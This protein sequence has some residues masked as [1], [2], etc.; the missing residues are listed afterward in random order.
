VVGVRVFGDVE[1]FL[2]FT[3]GIG[4]ERPMGADSSAKL[5]R[6]SDIVSANRNKAAIANLE[7]TMELKKPFVLPAVFGAETSAAEDENHWMLSL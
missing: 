7:F 6:L 4:K 3:R 1:I 5:I 2:D